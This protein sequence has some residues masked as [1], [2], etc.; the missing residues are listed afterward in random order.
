MPDSINS[1]GL[2]I[3]PPHSTTSRRALTTGCAPTC[4][5]ST[6][7]ARFPSNNTRVTVASVSTVRFFRR[8]AGLRY[9]SAVLHRAPLRWV[10][11]VSQNLRAAGMHSDCT[12]RQPGCGRRAGA[13]LREM[14]SGPLS[15]RSKY[16]SMLA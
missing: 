12:A 13:A 14:T 15:M 10:T 16:F 4:S 3:A 2:L 1:C 6:P 5:N 7:T 8:N 9:A 11:R